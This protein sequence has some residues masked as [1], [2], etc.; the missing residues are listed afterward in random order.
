MRRVRR[1]G[2][3]CPALPCPGGD[4]R[5]T[6]TPRY[7][8]TCPT[9]NGLSRSSLPR[10]SA[11]NLP[12]RTVTAR[13]TGQVFTTTADGKTYRPFL[14]L[15]LGSYGKVREDGTPADPASYDY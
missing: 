7:L 2:R 5:S 9:P 4:S 11:A 6:R 10:A 13:T 15:T 12:W 1:V 14:T 8:R 3:A